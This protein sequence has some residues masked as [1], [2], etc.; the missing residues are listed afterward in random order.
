MKRI[1]VATLL[2][3]VIGYALFEARRLLEGPQIVIQ[4]PK[5]GSATSSPAIRIAG[6]AHNISF[7]TIN[8][9]AAYTDEDGKF[10]ELLTPPPGITV[11]TVLGTDRFGRKAEKQ[12]SITIRNYCSEHG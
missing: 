4:T 7:L 9:K 2:L 5:D 8:D 10:G 6:E 11:V 3:L 12:V 1:I